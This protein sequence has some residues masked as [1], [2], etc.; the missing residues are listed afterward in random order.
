LTRRDLWLRLAR[1]PLVLGAVT[2]LV[3]VLLRLLPGDPALNVAGTSATADQIE[4]VRGELNLDAPVLAQYG[5]WLG[6]LAHGNLGQSYF[7]N[8]DVS[9]LISTRIGVSIRLMVYSMIVALAIAIPLGLFAG[10]RASSRFDRAAS[11]GVIAL[12][13]APNYVI[14]VVLVAVFAVRLQ[15]LPA[16]YDDVGLL[17][18]PW[19]H[20]RA[21][22]MPVVALAAGQIAVYMRLLRADVIGT[23]QSDFVAVARSKGISP[24]RL[25]VRHV[26][27]SSGF[28]V[29]TSAGVNIGALIG[30]TVIVERIF[31]IPGMGSLT[32]EAIVKRD[33]QT[34]QGCVIVFALIFVVATF[35]IDVAYGLLDPRIRHGNR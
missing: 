3:F 27:P 34:V 30:S 13:A 25:A 7:F 2:L 32:A 10:Y 12:Q 24:T 8:S 29:L 31:D 6:N 28:S 16:L 22:V 21:V 23:M 15:W 33:F 19:G 17:T 35:A 4:Q 5:T 14:G 18:D 11:A 9:D 26:L 20:V 1:V